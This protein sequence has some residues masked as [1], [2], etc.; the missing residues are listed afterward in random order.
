MKTSN[1]IASLGLL[2]CISA[3]VL[4]QETDH[5]AAATAAALPAIMA[6]SPPGP[7]EIVHNDQTLS[8]STRVSSKIGKTFKHRSTM[9]TCRADP[10]LLQVCSL[11]D[12]TS[13][14]SLTGTTVVGNKARARFGLEISSGSARQPVESYVYAVD[15]VL[16][17]G[18][19]TVCGITLV[20]LS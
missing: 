8:L 12:N 5:V 18:V 3:S 15:L 1:T 14:I 10:R 7:A 4:A 17:D 6:K 9:V 20:A 19:W 11:R 2:I 13:L 16:T